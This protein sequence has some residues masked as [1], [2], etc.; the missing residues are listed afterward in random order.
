M[1]GYPFD[2]MVGL[3]PR[4]FWQTFTLGMVPAA[5]RITLQHLDGPVKSDRV[6]LLHPELLEAE[7]VEDLEEEDVAQVF[8][9]DE[10]LSQVLFSLLLQILG[11]DIQADGHQVHEQREVGEVGVAE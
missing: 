5:D 9:S 1:P 4:S 8:E 2:E 10:A 3:T 6:L 11:V 7:P